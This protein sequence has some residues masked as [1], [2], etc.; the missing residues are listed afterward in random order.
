MSKKFRI[1][2]FGYTNGPEFAT[3]KEAQKELNL[4]KEQDKEACKRS[5]RIAT[6]RVDKDN[7][8]FTVTFGINLYSRHQIIDL[9]SY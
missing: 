4:W 2:S 1:D 3:L 5:F 9:T 7:M 6:L 8:G